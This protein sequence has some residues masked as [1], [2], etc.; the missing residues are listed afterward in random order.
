M[1]QSQPILGGL[2]PRYGRYKQVSVHCKRQKRRQN[3]KRFLLHKEKVSPTHRKTVDYSSI[4][5]I[6][7]R[8]IENL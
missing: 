2:L 7:K 1:V 3:D 6:E 4:F 8:D 5:Y